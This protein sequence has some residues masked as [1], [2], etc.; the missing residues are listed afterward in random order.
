MISTPVSLEIP[1]RTDADGAIRIGDTRVLLEIVIHA[2][3]QGKTPQEIVDSFP[4][5][6]IEDVYAVIAYYLHNSRYAAKFIGCNS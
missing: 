6:E 1:L 2:Y 3:Q 4:S 5:L